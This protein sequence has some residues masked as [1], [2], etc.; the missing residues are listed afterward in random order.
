MAEV[1][2][3]RDAEPQDLPLDGLVARLK[4]RIVGA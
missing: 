2:A 3:R 1:K 4:E